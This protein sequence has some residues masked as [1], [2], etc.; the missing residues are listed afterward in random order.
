MFIGPRRHSS[1]DEY[2]FDFDASLRYTRPAPYVPFKPWPAGAG[3]NSGPVFGA[4]CE[5]APL[6]DTY[7]FIQGKAAPPSG[8]NVNAP[9][10][11]LFR[12]LTNT[13]PGM[14][15]ASG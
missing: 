12:F 4:L 6:V 7:V 11:S 13:V 10:N 15:K 8:P 1:Y 2:P 3:G 5:M 14:T 9:V